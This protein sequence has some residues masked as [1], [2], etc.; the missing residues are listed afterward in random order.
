MNNPYTFEEYQKDSRK[1]AK[2]PSL[3]NKLIYPTLGLVGEAGEIA[4]KLKK[5]IRD[6]DNVLSPE[7]KDLLVKELGDVLWYIAQ[8]CTE[9]EVSMGDV[10]VENREKLYSRMERGVI[11][12]SGDT[13]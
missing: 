11:G 9:L 12:G 6:K 4:E 8:L 7:D 10:A 5:M 13:R 1:T 3:G 2:Y